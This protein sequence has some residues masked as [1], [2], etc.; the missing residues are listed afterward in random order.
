MPF[1]LYAPGTRK[2]NPY[3]IAMISVDGR[4]QERSTGT[5]DKREAREVARAIERELIA[6]RVPRPGDVVTFAKAAR[7][8]AAF[9]GIDLD[10]PKTHRGAQRTEAGAIARL[11]A[12]IGREPIAEM[13]QSHLVA[14]ANALL[15]G[16]APATKNRWVIKPGAAILHYAAEQKLCGWERIKK[17]KEKRPQT[18]AV[19]VDVAA[20]LVATAPVGPRRLLLV[21]LFRHG[22]RITDTLQ[23]RWEDN[24][25]LARQSVRMRIGKTDEWSEKRLHPEIFEMLAAI[26]PAERTGRLFPWETRSGVY[27]W[28]RPLARQIGVR[29]TPHM[30]RHSVG[31]WLNEEGAGLKTIMAALDHRDPASSIRY[32]AAD[33]EVVAAATARFAPITKRTNG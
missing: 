26:P 32:Q 22:T 3:W 10:D 33:I 17:F 15:P 29:F 5:T 19:S 8:Y 9:R 7:L 12:L 11:V 4:R 23:L 18:R 24:I 31:T 20:T 13:G 30:G 27:R 28:L 6:G 1:T 25:N 2:N 16:R 21:W 14:A